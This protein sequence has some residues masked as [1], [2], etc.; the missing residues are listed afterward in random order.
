MEVT[1]A[2]AYKRKTEE[3]IRLFI[4]EHLL[5]L[6]EETGLTPNSIDVQFLNHRPIETNPERC[7]VSGVSIGVDI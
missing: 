5:D 6:E 2:I 1:E 4:K 3:T 7:E